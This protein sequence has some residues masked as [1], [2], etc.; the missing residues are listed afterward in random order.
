MII[1]IFVYNDR[2]NI[3]LLMIKNNF[4]SYTQIEIWKFDVHHTWSKSLYI[5]ILT[6]DPSI[7]TIKTYFIPTKLYF[8][9]SF[10]KQNAAAVAT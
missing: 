8:L 1:C 9:D 2:I 6:Y 4:H 7:H 3:L 5:P 10:L